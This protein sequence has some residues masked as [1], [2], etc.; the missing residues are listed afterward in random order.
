[1]PAA[2]EQ[3][4]NLERE[5]ILSE[6]SRIARYLQEHLGQRVTAYL[7]GIKDA[8]M[9]GQWARGKRRPR[10]P[11]AFRLRQA[12]PA[13]RL[14]IETFGNETAKAWFFGTNMRLDDEA[15]A[16]VLR[17][18]ETPDDFRFVLPAARAFIEG[19]AG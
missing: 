12:Y 9:V 17:Y 7:S 8:K 15:P 6:I 13:A 11:S 18:G 4:E 16:Y 10:E 2:A 19:G 5:A 1:M 3:L 14:L